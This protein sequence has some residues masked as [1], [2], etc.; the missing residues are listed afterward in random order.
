MAQKLKQKSF[1][2][3]IYYE[4]N[5]NNFIVDKNDLTPDDYDYELCITKVID[6]H[7]KEV[8][9]PDVEIVDVA[10]SYDYKTI[11]KISK[12]NNKKESK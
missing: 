9:S 5:N 11:K 3:T 6:N 1:L 7:L 12:R 4:D 10:T 8:N 2:I